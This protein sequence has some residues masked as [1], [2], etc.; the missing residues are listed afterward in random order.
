[1]TVVSLR[2]VLEDFLST[3][4]YE[5]LLAPTEC[6]LTDVVSDITIPN[7]IELEGLEKLAVIVCIRSSETF[8]KPT[9]PIALP[10]ER[11]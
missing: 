2:L 3:N 11:G 10:S 7:V 9:P 1:M 4:P 8:V 6:T 5:Q